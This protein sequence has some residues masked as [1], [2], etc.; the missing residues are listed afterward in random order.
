MGENNIPGD[1]TERIFESD[2]I[3]VPYTTEMSH[4]D[5]C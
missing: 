5:W 1:Y 4:V 2:A 3:I